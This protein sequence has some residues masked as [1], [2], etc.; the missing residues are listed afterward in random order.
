MPRQ[1]PPLW[2]E[3]RD[4]QRRM[5]RR[6]L[7]SRSVIAMCEDNPGRQCG[8]ADDDDAAAAVGWDCNVDA[9]PSWLHAYGLSEVRPYRRRQTGS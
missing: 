4:G 5:K 7:T 2:P 3:E 1:L 8:D 9:N 6:L